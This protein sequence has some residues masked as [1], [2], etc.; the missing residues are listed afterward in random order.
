[1]NAVVNTHAY[2]NTGKLNFRY[3]PSIARDRRDPE[4]P[5]RGK[6]RPPGHG[7]QVPQVRDAAEK[8]AAIEEALVNARRQIAVAYGN[9]RTV[10]QT[11]CKLFVTNK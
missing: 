5:R 3:M 6:R 2:I 1:M 9:G 7:T 8:H 4:S 11:S 10:L